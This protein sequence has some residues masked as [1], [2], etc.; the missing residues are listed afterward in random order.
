MENVLGWLFFLI[1]FV[2]ILLS[3]KKNSY[4]RNFLLIA[5]LLRSIFVYIDNY[6]LVLPDSQLDAKNF[7]LTAR[8]FSKKYGL[9]VFFDFFKNDSFLISRIISIFYTLFGE[10]RIIAQSISVTL[11]TVSVYLVYYLCLLLWHQRSA[12]KAAWVAAIFPTL[13]LY[14]SQTLREPY[15]VF[16]LLLAMIGIAKFIIYKNFFSFIQAIASFYIL[17]LYHGAAVIGGLVFLVY[18][19][20]YLIKKQL[21]ILNR[22]KIN[23]FSFLF[24]V[25]L[26]IPVIL[27]LNNNLVFSYLGTFSNL[28]NLDHLKFVSNVGI[29]ASAAYP[30]WLFV[31]NNYELFLKIIVKIFYFLYSPFLWDIKKFYHLLGFFDGM[32][33][34]GLTIYI[35]CNLRSIWANP[36]TRFF[37]L[38]LIIYI[39]IHAI[40]VGN[41]GTAIRHRS[42]FVVFLIILAAP[43]I[44]RFIFSTK[45]KLYTK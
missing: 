1:I 28:I 3:T 13:V 41:F 18:V 11:G 7:E 42:K 37:L 23:I 43:K 36:I 45:K 5:F 10:S 25:S 32:L 2:F 16:F 26:F 30:N 39:I 12:Q 38:L 21:I 29:T 24:L 44:H 22:F 15:I 4:V 27:F 8:D 40:G 17:S 6:L 20:F 35:L 31:N 33:Y 14:S 19:I 9:L 34:I